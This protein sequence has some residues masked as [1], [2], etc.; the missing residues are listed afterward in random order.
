MGFGAV[1]LVAGNWFCASTV[2]TGDSTTM[3]AAA[4]DGDFILTAPA[5]FLRQR[6]LP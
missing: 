5:N 4:T 1:T 2:E 6:A 3:A